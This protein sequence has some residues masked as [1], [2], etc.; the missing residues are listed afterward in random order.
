MHKPADGMRVWLVSHGPFHLLLTPH[1]SLSLPLSLCLSL[2][3]SHSL[4]PTLPPSL[5]PSQDLQAARDE[6]ARGGVPGVGGGGSGSAASSLL[7]VQ[8]AQLRG[9]SLA[10]QVNKIMPVRGREGTR[11]EAR[12]E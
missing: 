1:Y 6:C 9:L 3:L 11:G 10:S 7:L 2:S 4:P 12:R 8:E 5:P